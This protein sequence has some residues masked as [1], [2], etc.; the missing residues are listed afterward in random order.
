MHSTPPE[1][2]VKSKGV[3]RKLTLNIL[4]KCDFLTE[5]ST[6]GFYCFGEKGQDHG[7]LTLLEVDDINI[8]HLKLDGS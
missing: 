1:V 2:S 7:G 3:K 8:T 5:D 4:D 6:P